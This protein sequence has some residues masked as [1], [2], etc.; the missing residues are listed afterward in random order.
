MKAPPIHW[1]SPPC[2]PAAFLPI[3]P[4]VA[5]S[6]AAPSSWTYATTPTW[7]SKRDISRIFGRASGIGLMRI[8]ATEN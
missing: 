5:N 7:V 4:T 3:T 6:M 2:S 8:G 1:P